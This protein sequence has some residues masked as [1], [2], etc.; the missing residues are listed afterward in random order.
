MIWSFAM[1][2]QWSVM[3]VIDETTNPAYTVDYM[4]TNVPPLTFV[5]RV[6][7]LWSQLKGHYIKE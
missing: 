7:E 4:S 3:K 5:Q 1:G 6:E 2:A